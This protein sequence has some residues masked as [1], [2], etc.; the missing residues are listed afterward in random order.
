M[1][2][3]VSAP[4]AIAFDNDFG[5]NNRAYV[6][7]VWAQESLMVLEENL[8]AANLVHR[9]FENEIAEY[10]DVV[11]TRRP[12]KFEAVRKVDSDSVT[13]QDADAEKVQVKLNQHL[14]TSFLIKDGEMTKSFKDLVT[15]FLTPAVRSLANGIDQIVLASTYEFLGNQVGKLGTDPTKATII[16]ANTKMNNN[17]VPGGMGQRNFI[18]SP[19]AEGALLAESEFTKVNEAGDGGIALNQALLGNKF[20]FNFYMDQNT[21]SIASSQTTGSGAINLIAGYAAGSTSFVIDAR[22]SGTGTLSVGMWVTIAGDMT[23]LRVTATNGTTTMT[24]ATGTRY[25]VANDAAITIYPAGAV[26]LTAGYAAGWVKDL[27]TK[28]FTD[29]PL[30]G[31]MLSYTDDVYGLINTPTAIKSSLNRETQTIMADDAALN[32]GPAGDYSLAIHPNAIALVTRPLITV[33]SEYGV[34]QAVVNYNGL[35]IRISM[36]Y[37]GNKQGMLVTADLLCGVKVLDA[38]LG[39]IM[40]G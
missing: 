19:N 9:S 1:T 6:P 21:P 23:P 20:G 28:S 34:R 37:D 25:A 4:K 31:Q 29:A 36:Q 18:L 7:E 32:V 33:P 15:E 39:C 12:G 2:F 5:T 3:V 40:L 27:V 8:V 38:N 10:G 30:K 26:D 11:N 17:N 22:G 13:I 16:A 14:H 35:S 24:V